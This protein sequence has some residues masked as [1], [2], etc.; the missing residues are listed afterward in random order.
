MTTRQGRAFSSQ[1]AVSLILVAGFGLRLVGLPDQ[2]MW[3]D[4]GYTVYFA[5]LP[6]AQ[7][8]RE[9]A[10]DTHPPGY[11]LVMKAWTHLAGWDPVAVRSLSA[12]LGIVAVSLVY[13]LG[14]DLLERRAA[15]V[16]SLLAA[17]SALLVWH[18]GEARMY[19]LQLT[20][21][22]LAS[23]L[24]VRVARGETRYV[25]WYALALTAALYTHYFALLAL[26]AHLTYWLF[27]AFRSSRRVAGAGL[28]GVVLAGTAFSPWGWYA[29]Q[30]LVISIP[31]KVLVERG[32]SLE[33]NDYFGGLLRT[34]VGGY[35]GALATDG[36]GGALALLL[37]VLAVTGIYHLGRSAEDPSARL[38][39]VALGTWMAIPLVGGYLVNLRF[40]FSGYVRQ[41][42]FVVPL[43]YLA[44]ASGIVAL[45]DLLKV[46]EAAP[47][48]RRG[49]VLLPVVVLVGGA[50]PGL[51]DMANPGRYYLR[52]SKESYSR[53][54][55][56]VASLARRGDA[57]LVEFPWQIGYF[58][59]YAPSHS[60]WEYYPP[61]AVWGSNQ[62]AMESGLD[63][64]MN[65]HP[66]L[67]YPFYHG[68][69][70]TMGTK[71]EPYLD[72]SQFPALEEW[73]E[74]TQLLLYASRGWQG[75]AEEVPCGCGFAEAEIGLRGYAVHGVNPSPGEV[76]GITLWWQAAEPPT[77][78]YKVFIHL[79][80]ASG[81]VVAQ[82]DAE[83]VGWSRRTDS[84][85]AGEVVVDRHGL[86][87]P[88][89][90][91]PGPYELRA[92]LY[93]SESGER[94]PIGPGEDSVSLGF[95]EVRGRLPGPDAVA[96]GT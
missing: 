1:I 40:P 9:T 85:L 62:A 55:S 16:A 74:S 80:A 57:L 26:A 32:Q 91:P 54:V 95:I 46:R 35:P 41:I 82:R 59:S 61:L 28:L 39:A 64:I 27:F 56:R 71:I 79:F 8:L 47:W 2:E 3:P 78:R 96:L 69:P 21:V 84:W 76:V 87:L 36:W 11:Y 13:R 94:L 53:L 18:S 90:L 60:L 70:L 75:D 45:P 34:A 10:L 12:L 37:A 44:A 72:Q 48:A 86:L 7:L 73:Y 93:D 5:T 29:G 88:A 33:A 77:R 23:V 89:D 19:P 50:L 30:R 92:G 4:E 24:A 15:L 65:D 81:S 58:R 20:T 6:A 51:L 22:L 63:Q 49:L 31:G 68:L 66:R 25:P 17:T 83:P 14:L 52:Q 42:L 43:L 38:T 67:W